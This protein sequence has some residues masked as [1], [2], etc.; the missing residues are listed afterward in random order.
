MVFHYFEEDELMKSFSLPKIINI[1]SHCVC[2]LAVMHGP[3]FKLNVTL[4]FPHV[5]IL[6]PSWA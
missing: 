4:T 3:F 2:A 5:H 1:F 6:F